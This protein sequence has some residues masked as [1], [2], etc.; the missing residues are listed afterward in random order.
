MG[1][2]FVAL[3]GVAV[4]IALLVLLALADR[5]SRRRGHRTRGSRDVALDVREMQ[6]DGKVINTVLGAAQRDIRWTAVS[7]RGE[8][9]RDPTP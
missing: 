7:R 8:R 2:P 4:L 9:P 3:A 6:R 5:R 1:V